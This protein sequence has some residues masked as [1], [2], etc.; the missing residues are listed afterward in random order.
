[1][2]PD[3]MERERRTTRRV[4]LALGLV[5]VLTAIAVLTMAYHLLQTLN[6]Q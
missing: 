6:A 1:M 4:M 2:N 5:V 3:E